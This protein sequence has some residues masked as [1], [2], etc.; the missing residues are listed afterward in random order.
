MRTD[1]ATR[2]S[3]ALRQVSDRLDA[4]S[5]AYA[6]TQLSPAPVS[7]AVPGEAAT[8]RA[9]RRLNRAA[10][11]IA[12]SV[13][14]DSAMEH[15]RGEFHNSAMWTPI[16]SAALSVAVSVHGH[17]DRRTRAHRGRDLVYAAA[18]L[19]GVIGTGFHLY[20]ITKKPGGFC[21]QNLFYSAPIGAPAA[22]SLSGLMGFL[23]ERVRANQP[24]TAPKVAGYSA[25]RA[26][27]ALTGASLLGT[28]GEAGLLHFRGAYHNPFMLLPVSVPPV[29][30]ALLANAAVGQIAGQAAFHPMVAA[31]DDGDGNRRRRVSRLWRVAQ[32][33]R[34]AQLAADAFT[35]PPLPAPTLVQRAGAGGLAALGLLEDHPDD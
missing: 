33:G 12:A 11:M 24:G 1:T 18:G 8:V 15:Y 9:A 30:A 27:A 14:A 16:V 3:L 13:L 19:T 29:A 4:L 7:I 6:A 17:T 20:N 32:H 28:V 21:W 22:L 23:S 5:K 31:R 25:G 26:V 35:G 10:G 34:M 2:S